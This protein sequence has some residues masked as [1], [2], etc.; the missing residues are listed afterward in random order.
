MIYAHYL[1]NYFTLAYKYLQLYNIKKYI[2]YKSYNISIR[3][4]C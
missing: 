3:L 2:Q 1:K 4:E